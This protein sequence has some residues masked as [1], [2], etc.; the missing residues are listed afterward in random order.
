MQQP[1]LE[2]RKEY[3]DIVGNSVSVVPIIGTKRSVRLRWIKPYTMER[4]TEVWI[5]RDLASAKI[6][7]GS[8]VAKD[9][10]KEP[11]FAF[12][13]AALMIL[14]NDIKIRLF[15]GFYWRWLARRY[16][17]QQ[18]LPIIDAGKKKAPLRAHYEIMAFSTDMM[19]DAM[20]MTKKEAE[21]YRA[22]LLL[23]QKPL[24]A[25]TSPNTD[26]PASGYSDGNGT[27]ATDAS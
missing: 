8:D 2:Q 23:A 15:Y 22:E 25:K 14:N 13:E 17:E 3:M 21:Q 9:L 24:S 18:M 12:K 11:Y 1:T 5:E 19:M 4:I 20:R 26:G 16:S 7:K 27:S 6:E 10:C